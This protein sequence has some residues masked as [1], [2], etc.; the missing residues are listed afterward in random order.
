MICPK[1]R[2]SQPD[3]IYC[4]LCG[5]NIERYA[6]Q[7]RKRRRSIAV[8]AAFFALTTLAIATFLTSSPKNKPLDRIDRDETGKS[9]SLLSHD[10]GQEENARLDPSLNPS[11]PRVKSEPRRFDVEKTGLEASL[12]TEGDNTPTKKE[13]SEKG[14]ITAKEWFEEGKGLDDDSDAEIECYLKARELDPSFAPAAFRLAAIYFRQANY[15][16]ADREFASFLK[17]ASDEDK[18]NYDIYEYYSLA[19]VERIYEAIDTQAAGEAEKKETSAEQGKDTGQEAIPEEREEETA[20]PESQTPGQETNE[21]VMTVV[22]FTQINGQII[23]PVVLNNL[24]HANVLVD[25]G[26]GIT[27][28]STALADELG[29]ESEVGRSVTLKTMAMDVQAQLARLHSIQVGNIN[30]Y[31]FPVAVAALPLE[32]QGRFQGILGMDFMNHYT[33]HIDNETLR[34]TLKPKKS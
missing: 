4:A 34:I 31:D 27:V 17:N 2:F 19:D 11:P 29:L 5:V 14:E 24:L 32:R 26:A 20:E 6:Q 25:T 23:V 28:L 18:K 22:G 33:I 13:E 16:M 3:D 7:K 30:R 1:C 12:P 21:D 8:L 15:E 9:P 10:T